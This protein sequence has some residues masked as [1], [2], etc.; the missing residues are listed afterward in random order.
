MLKHLVLACVCALT[1][2]PAAADDAPTARGQ[3][4]WDAKTVETVSGVVHEVAKSGADERGR[5]V[6]LRATL[7]TDAGTVELVLGPAWYAEQ[8]GLR[9]KAGDRIEVRGSRVSLAG[10]PAVVVAEVKTGGQT[11]KLRDEQGVPL[12][13]G[14]R[15]GPRRG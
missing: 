3:R 8:Q 14:G 9:L 13:R 12:W 4:L 15:R 7:E 6:G 2:A 1:V 11:V 10:K 5:G